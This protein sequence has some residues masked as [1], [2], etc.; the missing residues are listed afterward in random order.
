[1]TVALIALYNHLRE[2][3]LVYCYNLLIYGGLMFNRKLTKA[4]LQNFWNETEQ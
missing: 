4:S 1:M 3:Y 2:L